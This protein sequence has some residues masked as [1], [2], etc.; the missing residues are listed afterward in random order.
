M[1]RSIHFLVSD[2]QQLAAQLNGYGVVTSIGGYAGLAQG[3]QTLVTSTANGS[4]TLVNGGAA[5][6]SVGPGLQNNLGTQ[7]SH[8]IEKL[9]HTTTPH[10]INFNSS[11]RKCSDII[12]CS[13]FNKVLTETEKLV[14]MAGGGGFVFLY[15]KLKKEAESWSSRVYFHSFLSSFN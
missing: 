1:T 8:N 13:L 3:Q 2:Q 4:A 6:A 7:A 12:H 14:V 11:E 10:K 15:L 9:S 5:V